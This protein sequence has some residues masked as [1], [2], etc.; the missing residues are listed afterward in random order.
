MI[1]SI[2]AAHARYFAAAGIMRSAGQLLINRLQR[3]GLNMYDHFIVFVTYDRLLEFFVP[4]H[5]SYRVEDGCMH[6]SPLLIQQILTAD[7]LTLAV[8]CR[9]YGNLTLRPYNIFNKS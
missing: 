4:R 6:A 3:C 1:D 8:V 9:L 5:G 2:R 7:P